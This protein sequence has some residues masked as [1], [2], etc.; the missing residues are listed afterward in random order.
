[1]SKSKIVGIMTLIT[2]SMG[3]FLVGN[4]LAGEKFKARNAYHSVK[5]EQ[6]NVGDEEGHVVAVYESKAITTNLEGKWFSD[7]SVER[8]TG[9][10]D[11]NLKTGLGSVH[12]YAEMA[13]K[14]GNKYYYT[15]EGKVVEAG[16]PTKGVWTI[17]KGT[18][19]FEGITGK[20][21]WEYYPL[22]P[23]EGYSNWEIEVEL[24]R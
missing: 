10:W 3:I 9:L 1:M 17:V 20:G 13:D 12:G 14:D 11:I 15:L 8:N 16:K 19:K 18:G 4:V 22:G 23:G 6:V 7:G 21:T 24:P 2:F 5:W